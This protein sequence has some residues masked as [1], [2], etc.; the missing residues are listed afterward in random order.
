MIDPS[1]N[2]CPTLRAGLRIRNC[3]LVLNRIFKGFPTGKTCVSNKIVW[4][5]R[6]WNLTRGFQ[7]IIREGAVAHILANLHSPSLFIFS[8]HEKVYQPENKISKP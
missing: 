3:I 5:A 1:K 7:S 4:K 2:L 8:G 6:F